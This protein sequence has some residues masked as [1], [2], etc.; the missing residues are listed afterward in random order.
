VDYAAALN[1][2]Y[3]KGVTAEN[4][5][6]VGLIELLCPE[7]FES[8]YEDR[9]SVEQA[10]ERRRRREICR[11]L[12]AQWSRQSQNTWVW[13]E[14]FLKGGDAQD[15]PCVYREAREKALMRG[16]SRVP[17]QALPDG[18]GLQ[19]VTFLG[20]TG[21]AD[22]E[23]VLRDRI[24]QARTKPWRA[25][26][27]PL[28]ARWLDCNAELLQGFL[29]GSRYNRYYWP[30]CSGESEL[31]IGATG[32]NH[33]LIRALADATMARAMLLAGSGRTTEAAQQLGSLLRIGRTL[34]LPWP[35]T[36]YMLGWR[37]EDQAI[38]GLSAIAMDP[39]TRPS[40]LRRIWEVLEG[41]PRRRPV[42]DCARIEFC[43]GLDA[44]QAV[45]TGRLEDAPSFVDSPLAVADWNQIL[46]R[47]T[48]FWPLYRDAVNEA[49]PYRRRDLW[50]ALD[51]RLEAERDSMERHDAFLATWPGKAAHWVA[52]ASVRRQWYTDALYARM[53]HLSV[54][55]LGW[56]LDAAQS[57]Q[58]RLH[59]L[60]AA[61]AMRLDMGRQSPLPDDISSATELD[62]RALHD[63]FA[64]GP[65]TYRRTEDGFIIYSWGR[66]L[67]DDGG[68]P[69]VDIVI[70]YPQPVAQVEPLDDLEPLENENRRPSEVFWEDGN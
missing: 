12:G 19:G 55:N 14:E 24:V 49:D 37:I 25:D 22:S 27:F 36:V 53:L 26:E 56:M 10:G 59:L 15:L 5:L 9:E 68:D 43:M 70:R 47:I 45:A 32:P 13:A 11:L 17:S 31:A 3:G 57:W 18:E 50:A 63:L 28:V 35:V 41:L 20:T 42:L 8:G 21:V 2:K 67:K 64:A 52:P 30:M 65:L 33:A 46:R 54:S 48:A 39:R 38:R 7:I 58:M 66:D 44:V 60:R 40:G 61:I 1:A 62:E 51:R 4:N 23:D 29:G 6:A 69:E 16:E 34:D